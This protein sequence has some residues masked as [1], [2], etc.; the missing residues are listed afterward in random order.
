MLSNR[1]AASG[2][3]DRKRYAGLLGLTV[4]TLP[5]AAASLARATGAGLFWWW[6]PIW[7]FAIIP[8]LDLVIGAD[9]ANPPESLVAA[10]EADRYY[11]WCVY[12]YTPLQY[13][14]LVWA[15]ALWSRGGLAP[16]DRLGLAAT[17]G[18]VGGVGINAAHELGHKAER[19]ER[20][21]S[22]VTLAQ[23]AYGTSTSSTTAG[24]TLASPRPPIRP[25]PASERASGHF[26]RAPSAGPSSAPGTSKRAAFGGWASRRC[27]SRTTSSM[28][29]R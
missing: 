25:P 13:A 1:R 27:G 19:V 28:H 11:R 7:V 24:I 17:V 5:F 26:G 9:S 15:C 12:L 16:I 14:A 23:T 3:R 10:L 22:K 6:G 29:G 4:P 20:W 21:L 18:V 2:W 8:V